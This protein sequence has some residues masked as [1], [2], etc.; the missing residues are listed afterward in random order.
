MAA[1][2]QFLEALKLDPAYR[3]A[4]INKIWTDK[5]IRRKKVVR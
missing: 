1:Q 2:H 4:Q 3:K 5:E